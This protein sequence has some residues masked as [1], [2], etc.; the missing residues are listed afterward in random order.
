MNYFKFLYRT[1]VSLGTLL[2]EADND[3]SEI[4]DK[5]TVYPVMRFRLC[6]KF[7]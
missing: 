1:H 5:V 6:G 4:L 2:E 7:F 3:F